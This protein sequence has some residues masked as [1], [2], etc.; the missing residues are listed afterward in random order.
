MENEDDTYP[1]HIILRSEWV[2]IRVKQQSRHKERSSN[3]YQYHH[4]HPKNLKT[5]YTQFI[6]AWHFFTP[7]VIV[8]VIKFCDFG[9]NRHQVGEK[10]SFNQ[11]LKDGQVVA[12]NK[13][14]CESEVS[15]LLVQI[16]LGLEL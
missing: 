9:E 15:Q 16:F 11:F 14:K 10:S 7:V 2:E 4:H 1:Y 13:Q 5:W 3:Y 8:K 12:Q 6:P